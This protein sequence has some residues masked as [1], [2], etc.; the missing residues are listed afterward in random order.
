MVHSDSRQRCHVGARVYR[1]VAT[2]LLRIEKPGNSELPKLCMFTI[3]KYR[4]YL[5]V[6]AGQDQE[7]GAEIYA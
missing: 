1:R 7:E 5:A 3:L 4:D 6:A 2:T